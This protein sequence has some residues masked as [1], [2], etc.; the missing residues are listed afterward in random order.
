MCRVALANCH[1]T[2][3]KKN[4]TPLFCWSKVDKIEN[5]FPKRYSA[6]LSYVLCWDRKGK[7]Q[8]QK[9]FA[10]LH[11]IHWR[12]CHGKQFLPLQQLAFALVALF[13]WILIMIKKQKFFML[14][15]YIIY[16]LRLAV[17]ARVGFLSHPMVSN[18]SLS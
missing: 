4:P 6:L 5:I 1:Q 17:Y 11:G 14:K 3:L 10:L 16:I 7:C 13:L 2:H 12:I 9:I 8:V 15:L 18:H